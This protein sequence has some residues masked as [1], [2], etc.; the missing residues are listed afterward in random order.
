M[1][2]RNTVKTALVGL[3]PAAAVF[4]PMA[5]AQYADIT[6]GLDTA[7][8]ITAVIAA[9]ALLAGVGFAKWAAKK[10]GTFFG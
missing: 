1:I 10:L 5:H 3:A 6:T 7:T 2:N 8:V 4:A 9:A